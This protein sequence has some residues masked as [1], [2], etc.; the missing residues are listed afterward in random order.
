MTFLIPGLAPSAYAG[1]TRPLKRHTG[2]PGIPTMP[3]KLVPYT[4]HGSALV[5][6]KLGRYVSRFVAKHESSHLRTG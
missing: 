1:L 3:A 6:M 2:S 5:G 4:N